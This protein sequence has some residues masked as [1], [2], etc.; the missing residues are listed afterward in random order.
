M[1]PA[2]EDPE[3]G[4]KRSYSATA[5]APH[6][7]PTIA[8]S[9]SVSISSTEPIT[10]LIGPATLV[11]RPDDCTWGDALHESQILADGTEAIL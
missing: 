2:I 7:S 4:W 10:L 1:M 5:I 11:F 3:F 8:H 9:G 6:L